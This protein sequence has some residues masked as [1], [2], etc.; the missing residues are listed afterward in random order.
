MEIAG[1]A[2]YLPK[3]VLTNKDLEIMMDTSDE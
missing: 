2:A 1:I 3:R